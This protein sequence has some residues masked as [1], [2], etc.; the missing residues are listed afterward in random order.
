MLKLMEQIAFEITKK[1][2]TSFTYKHLDDEMGFYSFSNEPREETFYL[3][4]S[5]D[6]VEVEVNL[7]RFDPCAETNNITLSGE[8]KVRDFLHEMLYRLETSDT[9]EEFVKQ[10]YYLN[11]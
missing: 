9:W 2:D 3:Y 8:K 10:L 1:F 5:P 6:S 4:I 11:Y 7:F